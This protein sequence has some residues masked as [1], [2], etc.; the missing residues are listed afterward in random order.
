MSLFESKYEM[1]IPFNDLDPMNIVWHGNYIKYM[2]QARCDMFD[3]LNYT[4]YDMKDDNYAYPVAKMNTKYIQ[5]LCFNQ[6]IVIKTILQEIEP[7]IRI[8]YELY[9]K[10]T[11]N[12]VFEAETM[13][14]AVDI[15]T[16]NS[17][18]VAPKRL[19]EALRNVDE[20]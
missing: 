15:P 19:V 4:Y 17:L 1:K 8:K 16:R 18:Y 11:Q 12:K 6:E 2:E 7:A 20:K 13:Q 5:P 14:I 3:K 10:A 9:D